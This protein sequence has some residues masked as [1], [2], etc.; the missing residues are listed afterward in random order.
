MP[1]PP[2][3]RLDRTGFGINQEFALA[4]LQNGD[5]VVLI[6]PVSSPLLPS[7]S[8]PMAIGLSPGGRSS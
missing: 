8:P 7:D 1:L 6:P 3:S 5:Q 2:C 4:P